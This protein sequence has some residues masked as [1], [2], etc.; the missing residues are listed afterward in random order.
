MLYVASY[1]GFVA[2]YNTASVTDEPAWITST[3]NK[4]DY[5]GIAVVESEAT[6]YVG[7]Y[8]GAASRLLAL[9]KTNGALRWSYTAE[10]N[11]TSCPAVDANNIIHFADENGNWYALNPDGT[12]K[13]KEKIGDQIRSSPVIADYGV[14]YFTV[15]ESGA[16]QL[17]A[18]DINAGPANSPWPQA[19]QNAQRTGQQK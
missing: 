19:G 3:Y 2:A 17:V 14:L 1:A 7:T 13:K 8:E 11:I 18:I 9:N 6:I 15:V 16:C 10:A 4:I 12:L 5:S